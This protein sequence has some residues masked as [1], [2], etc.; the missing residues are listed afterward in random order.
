MSGMSLQ[1][2]EQGEWH[3]V[4]KKGSE[5]ELER[6]RERW[7]WSGLF[8]AGS[9]WQIVETYGTI[10]RDSPKVA[11]HFAKPV[12]GRQFQVGSP[13]TGVWRSPGGGFRYGRLDTQ[14]DPPKGS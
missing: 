7:Q 2:W 11:A 6:L 5:L 9:Q 13:H 10:H 14:G 12:V 4:N 3:T 1:V 8:P